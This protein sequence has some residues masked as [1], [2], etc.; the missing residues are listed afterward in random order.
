MSIDVHAAGG[1]AGDDERAIREVASRLEGCVRATDTLARAGPA[2]FEII[3]EDLT[4]PG[5]AERAKVN[6]QEVLS[7]PLRLGEREVAFRTNVTLR[8]YP[9]PIDSAPI[10]YD[11]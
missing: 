8:F 6:V 11:S 7:A 2:N 3:L 4:Q 5:H 1:A 9:G 10:K